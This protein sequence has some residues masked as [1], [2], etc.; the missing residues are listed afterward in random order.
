MRLAL[1]V[2]LMLSLNPQQAHARCGREQAI[3]SDSAGPK[4]TV[5]YFTKPGGWYAE[6]RFEGWEGGR[7]QWQVDGEINCTNGVVFCYL[8]VPL[9]NKENV[10]APMEEIETPEGRPDYM[11]FAHLAQSTY[12]VQRYADEPPQL[13]VKWAPGTHPS[14]DPITLP[15]AYRFLA[16]RTPG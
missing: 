10:E 7:L 1:T 11:V 2:A 9:S 3:W 16:C 12:R 6:L 5:I 13:I 8:S 15:S 14:G 4:R